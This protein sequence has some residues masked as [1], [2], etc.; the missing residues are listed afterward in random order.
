MSLSPHVEKP[1]NSKRWIK[2]SYLNKFREFSFFGLLMTISH[3]CISGYVTIHICAFMR[4]CF[5]G[6]GGLVW[7]YP[8]TS[9]FK[10]VS[11]TL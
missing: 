8:C 2:V 1:L 11:L 6:G 10:C 9:V 4:V 7:V 5:F 3:I